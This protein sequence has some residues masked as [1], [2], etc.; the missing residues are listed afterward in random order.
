MTARGRGLP[1]RQP[2]ER[3][4]DAGLGPRPHRL[5]QSD[6]VARDLPK[7]EKLLDGLETIASPRR[8]RA[9]SGRPDRR[10]GV[11]HAGHA[12]ARRSSDR[13]RMSATPPTGQTSS[14]RRSS[15]IRS[16]SVRSTSR[17]HEDLRVQAVY[18]TALV[19]TKGAQELHDA[20]KTLEAMS[21][22]PATPQQQQEMLQLQQRR[23]RSDRPA[24]RD[25]RRGWP[26]RSKRPVAGGRERRLR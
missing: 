15:A 2:R 21:A 26:R 4:A 18:D 1:G 12:A 24:E 16:C 14:S 8:P 11:E 17:I 7:V 13:S 23:P 5:D 9:L 19:F 3:Q 6:I 20:A 22:R 10:P 25:F